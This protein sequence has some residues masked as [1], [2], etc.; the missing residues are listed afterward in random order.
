LEKSVRFCQQ[1]VRQLL[2]F[3]R[4]PASHAQ[5]ETLRT[6]VEAVVGFLSPS[7]SAMGANLHVDLSDGIADLQVRADRN[8]LETVLLILLSNSLDA[9][10][11]GGNINL[12]IAQPSALSVQL[13][14]EDDGCGISPVAAGHLFEPFFTTKPSGKGTGLGLALAK[15]IIAEHRGAIDLR[16]RPGRGAIATVTL[17][18]YQPSL[19]Q[20]VSR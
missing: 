9:S 14:I 16:A 10:G 7:V 19:P 6:V 20:E 17:P 5:P 13:T 12:R 1:F 4:R 15:N 11:K 2:E 8:Q 3:S 18:L